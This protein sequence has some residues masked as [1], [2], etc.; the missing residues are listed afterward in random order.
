MYSGT[1][2]RKKSGNLMGVHQKI[3]RVARKQIEQFLPSQINFPSAK[4]ILQF[5]GKNGPDGIKHKSPAVDEPW[6][7]IN[8]DD[9][10]D[11]NLLD[12]V[13]QHVSN[14]TKALV[15]GNMSRASFEAAWMAHA[16]T[17]G[18]TPPHHFPMEEKLEE[19]RGE[20]L[21]TRNSFLKKNL[22]PGDGLKQKVKNNWQYWGAKGIMTTHFAFEIGVATTVPYQRFSKAVPDDDIIKHVRHIGYRK[23][24][25]N[26]IQEVSRLNMYKK[27]MRNGWNRRLAK[28]TNNQLMPI[29]VRTVLIG[30]LISAE[31]AE[32]IK[33]SES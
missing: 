24:F 7:F 18:L 3:D 5:E 29:I 19:I 27:F 30:W 10:K 1:T 2:F 25:Y 31:Q 26:Q 32:K 15:D 14:L 12:M 9:P 16:V 22:M 33:L 21:E 4:E 6:H 11:T 23:Y 17:D 20:G 13:D 8:P 28:Q